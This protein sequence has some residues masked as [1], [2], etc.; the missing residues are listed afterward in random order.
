MSVEEPT[1]PDPLSLWHVQVLRFTAFYPPEEEFAFS[2]WW[3]D[4]TGGNPE[5]ESKKHKENLIAEEGPFKN[6][7]LRLTKSPLVID[8]RLQVPTERMPD[9]TTGIP[10][11]GTF[12]E[13]CG[14]FTDLSKKLF[15]VNSFPPITRMAFGCVISLPQPNQE[16]SYKQLASLLPAVQIDTQNTRDFVYRV[17]RR[18]PSCVNIENL[19]I[20]RTNKWSVVAYQTRL[21]LV[22]GP[23]PEVPPEKPDWACQL[24]LDINTCQEFQ[25]R[26]PK[27]QWSA[28]LDELVSLGEE[29]IRNGDVA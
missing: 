8:L 15:D 5:T 17:N 3:A 1:Q 19:T 21:I 14:E 10:T 22:S 13:L 25:G 26:L 2:G 12:G 27:E 7:W 6:G 4:L 24:V 28:V 18:R 11:I 20:N 9:E 29:I 16:L 23:H